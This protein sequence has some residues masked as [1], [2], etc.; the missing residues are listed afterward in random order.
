MTR[1]SADGS[2]ER[3]EGATGRPWDAGRIA[4]AIAVLVLPVLSVVTVRPLR[5]SGGLDPMFYLGYVNDYPALAARFGQTYHGNRLSYLAIDR[6]GAL[7]FGIEAGYVIVRVLMLVI[8]A[9][10]AAAI[11]R[12]LGGAPLALVLVALTTIVP[13]LVTQL[14][15]THYDGFTTV[16]ALVAVA[17]IV[18]PR[19]HRAVW[20]VVAGIAIALSINGNIM[21][22]VVWAAAVPALVALWGDERVGDALA[23]L[24]R[25]TAGIITGFAG[26]SLLLLRWYPEGPY[27]SETI[28][29]RTAL[30][31]AGD[32]TWFTPLRRAVGEAP[33]LVAL[34]V[35]VLVAWVAVLRD[36]GPPPELRAARGAAAVWGS[37][38]AVALAVLHAG[39]S[40]G[41]LG[42]SYYRIYLLPA[43][44]LLVGSVV[45]AA[46]PRLGRRW[47]WAVAAGVVA[48]SAAQRMLLQVGP[49]AT[50]ITS[51]VLAAAAGLTA[52][53]V[54]FAPQDRRRAVALA[55]AVP[56]LVAFATP[57]PRSG[58]SAE[59]A[60]R[61]VEETDVV[62]AAVAL[63]DIVETNVPSDRTL[64][65]WHTV[66]GETERTL[67]SLNMV[68]YGT[69]DGRLHRRADKG[70]AGMPDL[71][72]GSVIE[73]VERDRPMTIVLLGTSRNEVSDGFGALV[74]AGLAARPVATAVLDGESFDV[75]V[76]L[77][78]I[79]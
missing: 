40:M 25:V 77:I 50:W 79:D 68:Y 57:A 61:D 56:L 73:L 51:L 64:R 1:T 26:L 11:G 3:A 38:L 9:A 46:L 69:G 23:G 75:H 66:E 29:I 8:A 21:L 42:L 30:E 39:F 37:V 59:R 72:D 41:W 22:L 5:R 28:A 4:V 48:A 65:F 27:F 52:V 20:Q 14:M 15:W 10:A 17:A 31:L 58:S 47:A 53:A 67:T 13:W 16:H 62:R 54:G 55:A 74:G 6:A 34:V 35:V 60:A 45:G 44:L 18:A 63:Q 36:P 24:G 78:G 19:S 2:D 71:E 33:I 32:D 49:S 43:A 12:R 76:L 7:L 70:F